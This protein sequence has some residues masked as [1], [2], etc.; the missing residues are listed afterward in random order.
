MNLSF[1]TSFLKKNNNKTLELPQSLLIKELKAVAD[2]SNLH[3]FENMTIY[4]H[5]IN[6]FIPLLILDPNRG[7]FLFEYKDWSYDELKN[8]KIE[9]ATNQESSK[10]TLAFEKSHTFIKRKF[11]ELTHNDGVP[12]FNYL[13]MQ[14]LNQ[15]EYKH[16]DESFQ[17]L[18][19]E[20]KIMFSDSSQND[21]LGK[22]MK[23]EFSTKPLPNV[24]DIMCTLL[25]QY[26]ILDKDK[27]MHL[28]SKEQMLF[29]DYKLA[30]SQ[31]LSA[32]IGSGKTSSILLKAILEKLKNPKLSITIIK[33]T[34]LACDVLK[35][36]LLDTIE[37]AIIELDATSIEIITPPEIMSKSYKFADLIICDD[38]ELYSIELMKHLNQH[39]KSLLIVKNLTEAYDLTFTKSFKDENR[40]IF[41]IQANPHAKALQTI[42]TLLKDNES[43]EILVVSNNL[44]QIKLKD[45]LKYFIKDKAVLLDSSKNLIDQE[46]DNLLLSNYED[47]NSIDA[48]YVILMDI[49]YTD[50][51][52][53]EY[54]YNLSQKD[55]YILYDEKCDNL[56]L[57][58]SKFESNKE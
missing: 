36:K 30:H 26:C 15:D 13:L 46:L 19:P 38:S 53:L 11:N 44:S 43:K 57:L 4:H 55:V 49:C 6:F 12:I 39:K 3:I 22:I 9:K 27:T 24:S 14:N 58:R 29:I 10:N 17:A 48:K 51:D 18:L 41:F 28:A 31:T 25:I 35:K 37:H 34:I 50:I 45:D 16:L 23:S 56:A 1:F 8:A 21:I 2:E 42:A 32:P 47:V 7:L 54:A 20:D 52:K 33:P 5:G 40:K